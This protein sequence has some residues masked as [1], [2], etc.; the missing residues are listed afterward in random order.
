MPFATS[1]DRTVGIAQ[2]VS[3]RWSSVRINT[4]SGRWLVT[5]AGAGSRR[6]PCEP[7]RIL[8]PR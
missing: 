3:Q 2:S 6:P 7:H 1:S 8:E 4:M 5:A